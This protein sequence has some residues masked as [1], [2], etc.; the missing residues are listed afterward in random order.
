MPSA[1]YNNIIYLYDDN[2]ELYMTEMSTVFRNRFSGYDTL[3]I[4][5]RDDSHT[6]EKAVKGRLFVT[7]SHYGDYDG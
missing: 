1:W 3:T 6:L 2:D 4:Y 5:C 7:K